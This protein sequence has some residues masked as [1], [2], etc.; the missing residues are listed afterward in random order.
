VRL[1]GLVRPGGTPAVIVFQTIAPKQI[2]ALGKSDCVRRRQSSPD[3]S[4]GPIAVAL[5]C[6]ISSTT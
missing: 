3:Q 1:V 6:V 4:V 2:V 5:A